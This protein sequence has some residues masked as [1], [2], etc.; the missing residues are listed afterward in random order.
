[1]STT[2]ADLG[3]P[4]PAGAEAA[5][6]AVT[7]PAAQAPEPVETSAPPAFTDEQFD[8]FLTDPRFANAVDDRAAQ[9][10]QARFAEQPTAP[11]PVPQQEGPPP[12]WDALLDP[13]AD[14]WG[15][16]FVSLQQQRDEYLLD[17][18]DRRLD[19]RLGPIVQSHETAQRT[20][21]EEALNSAISGRWDGISD[22]ELG[23]VKDVA[24]AIWPDLRRTF[25]SD[26]IATDRALAT[27]V[28][29]VRAISAAAQ[30]AATQQA[31]DELH[32]TTSGATLPGGAAPAIS[33]PVVQIGQRVV[34]RVA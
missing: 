32:A 20:S 18:F 27:A 4:D 2:E 31:I 13:M 28:Q 15:S 29:R 22:D 24:R 25:G 3:A 11:A 33:A 8:A 1:M 17:E 9:I 6:P 34:D 30:P 23:L 21:D 16:R 14:G 19:E 7:D 26:D 12:D 10:A 5:A